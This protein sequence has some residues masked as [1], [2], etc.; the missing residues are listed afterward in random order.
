MLPETDVARI[1]RW[2]D[3]R[4]D[5]HPAE[6][7]EQRVDVRGTEPVGCVEVVESVVQLLALGLQLAES[8][9]DERWV[10]ARLDRR[11][12]VAVASSISAS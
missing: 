1:R 8:T 11:D 5:G 3:V 2:V 10:G 12:E 7:D 9:V 6:F 4:N